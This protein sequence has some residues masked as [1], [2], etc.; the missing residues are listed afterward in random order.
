MAARLSIF[1]KGLILILSPILLETA[2]VFSLSS[3]L[4]KID[5]QQ[6]VESLYRETAQSVIK[7]SSLSFDVCMYLFAMGMPGSG[8]PHEFFDGKILELK[9]QTARV[10]DMMGKDAV[11]KP[12]FADVI[13]VEYSVIDHFEQLGKIVGVGLPEMEVMGQVQF[14]INKIVSM[15]SDT[16]GRINDFVDKND[17]RIENSSKIIERLRADHLRILL[18][19]V[20]FN[21]VLSIALIV[22]YQRAIIRRLALIQKNTQ[23]LKEG[24]DLPPAL[25]GKDE[26]ALLDQSFHAMQA[27]LKNTKRKEELF[28]ENAADVICVLDKNNCF[29]K[30]NAASEKS[31]GIPPEMLLGEKVDSILSPDD[32]EEALKKLL[33]CRETGNASFFECKIMRNKNE[34]VEISWSVYYEPVEDNLYCVAN[35]ISLRKQVERARERYISIVSHDLKKPIASISESFTAVSE[36]KDL[37]E[38]AASKISTVGANLGR[39]LS[40]VNELSHR[41]SMGDSNDALKIAKVDLG[42]L[43]EGAASDIEGFARSKKVAVVCYTLNTEIEADEGRFMQVL[44]NLLSNAV[45]FSGENSQVKIQAK[46]ENGHVEIEIIDSGRGVPEDKQQ[47]IFDKYKQVDDADGKRSAGTGLGLPIC[48][49][50]VE[51]HSGTIGVRSKPNE[52]ST[53][54]LRIP[55][56]HV[57]KNFLEGQAV[58]DRLQN[59]PEAA[60]KSNT[61]EEKKLPTAGVKGSR[62]GFQNVR[63]LHKGLVLVGVP[64]LFEIALA[65]MLTYFFMQS[66]KLASNEVVERR[67]VNV[68]NQLTFC[69]REMGIA[70]L[71]PTGE[72]QMYKSFDKNLRKTIFLAKQ[73]R[74]LVKD[75]PPRKK[76][77]ALIIS[78]IKNCNTALSRCYTT[79]EQTRSEF[80]RNPY[81]G[82]QL[83]FSMMKPLGNLTREMQDLIFDASRRTMR[84]PEQQKNLREAQDKLLYGG[85]LA[86]I[87]IGLIL[88]RMFSNDIRKRLEQ[89]AQNTRLLAEEK[90]LNPALGGKDEIAILDSAFHE[91]AAELSE[92]RK[93]ERTLFDNSNQVICAV[94]AEMKMTGV[95]PAA[96]RLWG[97]SREE[98]LTTPLTEFVVEEDRAKT[99]ERL[100]Q[101]DSNSYSTSFENRISCKGGAIADTLWSVTRVPEEADVFCMAQDITRQKEADRLRNEFLSIISHDLR[102]PLSGILVTTAM[103]E[104]GGYGTLPEAA[105]KRL[106]SVT[107]D[108]NR[109]LELINDLLDIEKLEAGMMLL[110][111]ESVALK[112][113]SKDLAEKCKLLL[114]EKQISLSVSVDDAAL[115]VDKDRFTQAIAN[116]LNNAIERSSSGS[117]IDILADKSSEAISLIIRDQAPVLDENARESIFNRFAISGSNTDNSRMS[118]LAIPLSKS[119]ISV[120]G[121]TVELQSPVAPFSSSTYGNEF[122]V[123]LPPTRIC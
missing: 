94:G 93:R 68:S 58:A 7:M 35:D 41:K 8:V 65:G 36:I 123:Q 12:I 77:V 60:G 31:W 21:I 48:K 37:P 50:I 88:A 82:L 117:S 56:F 118:S 44:V 75:D 18:L 40:L 73:L 43:L 16:S 33:A 30:L 120:H 72:S 66:E 32:S 92:A 14:T 70:L 69:Y 96:S 34:A 5:K 112:D 122:V 103:L 76:R 90:E 6:V 23:I 39:L 28:F 52:G 26:I 51:Q 114:Q 84:S 105:V 4:E 113:L 78:K 61:A 108:V 59:A 19:A 79:R 83:V 11:F 15:L 29:A 49:Q 10:K 111:Y 27:D 101:P 119:I 106:S 91:A 109:L 100:F 80:E 104:E 2:I 42:T 46:E 3:V 110:A 85:L 98:L 62:F 67:I 22:Y 55:K 53:F 102:T 9:Q 63:L 1:H 38:K 74:L 25:E 64:L 99:T 95:N 81:I 17:Q 107:N 24:R 57:T 13:S 20:V 71:S 89:V 47:A 121:G 87:A 97:Y 45:K 54:W 115:L 116:L 86:N